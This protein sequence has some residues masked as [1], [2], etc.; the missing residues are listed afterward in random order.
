MR[1]SNCFK[2]GLLKR[3][4]PSNMK[5]KES[6][7]LA[8]HF[9]E[10]GKGNLDLKYHDIALICIY[11]SMLHAAR[12]LLFRDGIK[13]RSHICVVL[14]LREKY[15]KQGILQAGFVNILDIARRSRH[16]TQYG[17]RVGVTRSEVLTLINDS[18]EFIEAVKEIVL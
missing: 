16:K 15:V 4:K 3:E 18:K 12:A 13:E 7:E 6:L 5:V 10:R 9:L 8:K 1:L 11:N 17:G 2:E 14:Y